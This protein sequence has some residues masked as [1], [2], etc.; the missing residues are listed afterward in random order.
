[1]I[2][3]ERRSFLL[4][5]GALLAAFVLLDAR[6]AVAEP[7]APLDVL[8][9]AFAKSPGLFAKFHE[10][11]Q[12]ALL[13]APLKSD[14]TVHFDRA[15]GLARHTLTPSKKSILLS[16]GTLT[17]WD[18]SKTEVISLSSQPGLRAFAEAFTMFLAADRAGLERAFKLDFTGDPNASWKL[19][20]APASP[21]LKKI[22]TE[23]EVA[24]QGIVLSTLRVTEASGDVGTTTFSEVD[25]AKQY[26]PTEAATVFRVPGQAP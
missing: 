21:E 12:I 9:T 23:L 5:L 17:V 20:L 25:A 1:V 14:G 19:K 8:F 11:K 15:K 18:G 10:E 6:V 24:G 16:G 3:A 2:C 7:K 13:V 22:V 26:T 4:L